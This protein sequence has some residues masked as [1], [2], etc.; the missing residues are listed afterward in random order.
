MINETAFVDRREA[1]WKRLTQLSDRA[2]TSPQNLSPE[3]FAEFVR[4]YRRASADLAMIRTK[5]KNVQLAD[6]L[7]DMVGRAYGILYREPRGSLGKALGSGVALAAQTVRKRKWFMLLSAILFFGSGFFSFFLMTVRPDT[8]AYF[9]PEGHEKMFE[10]WKSG[11]FDERDT[12][13]NIVMSAFYASNNPRVAVI[14]GSVAAATFGIGTTYILVSNGYLLGT[15]A[16]ELEPNGL[17]GHLIVSVSPHGVPELSG[18]VV[19]GAAG[20]VMAWA[21]INPGRRKR[22]QA[23]LEA[24]KDAIVLLLTAMTLMFI[25]APIEGFFSFNRNVPNEAKAIFA[26]VSAIAWG[27]FW[28]GYGK[29][30]EEREKSAKPVY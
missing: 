9:L 16:K 24:G 14:A 10:G 7:N 20:F 21:L 6:F 2:E 22:G 1:D 18:I 4:L 13:D 17:I 23:L 15:L 3:E 30:P 11:E 29:T 5:S 19:S 26:I 27:F 25:A 12:S 8:K 28:V